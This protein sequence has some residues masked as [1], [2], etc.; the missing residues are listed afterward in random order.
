MNLKDTML[1]KISQSQ[2]EKYRRIPL[3]CGTES[4]QV[5]RDRKENGCQGLG[6]GGNGDLSVLMCTEFQLR[7]MKRFWRGVVGLAARQRECAVCYGT[8]HLNTV[9]TVNFKY[10]SPQ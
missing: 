3:T 1:S 10:I 8:V 7:K 5:H 6:G 4:S 9:R 2:K